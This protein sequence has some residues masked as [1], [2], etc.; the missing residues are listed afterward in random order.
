M[1]T[2]PLRKKINYTGEY[3]KV[4]PHSTD[5]E[6]AIL[7]ALLLEKHSF[8]EVSQMLKPEYFYSE[9]HQKIYS[10][11]QSL[12]FTHNAIDLLTVVDKLRSNGDL[13]TVGGMFGLTSLTNGVVSSAHIIPHCMIVIQQWVK[14]ELIRV[15]GE[16]L[17]E[18]Y[19]DTTD[20]FEMLDKVTEQF[21]VVNYELQNL[22]T[23]PLAD[24]A[25]KY[26][27]YRN[28]AEI[29]TESRI[30]TG[31]KEWDNING[32]LFPGGVFFLAARPGMGKTAFVVEMIVKMGGKMPIG[33]INLEMSDNQIVQRVIS[34]TQKIDND[35]FKLSKEAAPDDL[36]ERIHAGMNEFV[37]LKM[38]LVSKAGMTIEAIKAKAKYWKHKFGIR[39]LFI[40]YLQI[41]GISEER[42]RYHNELEN[43]NYTLAQIGI[44]AKDLDIPI[45]VLSQ[46]NRD[47]YKRGGNKEPE[48]SD[49]KGSGKI[50]EIAYQIGFLHRPEYFGDTED[51]TGETTKDLAYLIIKKHRDGKLGKLKFKFQGQYSHFGPW[52]MQTFNIP[53][54]GN[55]DEEAPF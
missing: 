50:E 51:E 27:E 41:I 30:F 14:R 43:L 40:D 8:N 26:L 37:S 54:I 34:N 13:D 9:A 1:N 28:K 11:I 29:D 53:A 44:L 21:G 20:V 24:L 46:L 10:A 49:M 32:P 6:K 38:Q 52:E 12:A 15:G 2:K 16:T 18:A 48:I 19:D 33:F 55:G 4:P 31:F 5:L 39:V 35:L 36:D 47:L 3:G 42:Q 17:S 25:V 23:A 22:Q 7:G 45:I